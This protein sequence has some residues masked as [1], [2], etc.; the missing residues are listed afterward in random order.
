MFVTLSIILVNWFVL[1][2][3]DIPL[4]PW[5]C[6]YLAFLTIL[7]RYSKQPQSYR[8]TVDKYKQILAK[9]ENVDEREVKECQI[10]LSAKPPRYYHCRHCSTCIY[11]LDHHCEFVNNCIGQYNFKVYVHLLINGLLHGAIVTM[12]ALWKYR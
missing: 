5:H 8:L 6:F 11:R 2:G 1:T 3:N 7:L 12:I 10:C 4:L 9:R